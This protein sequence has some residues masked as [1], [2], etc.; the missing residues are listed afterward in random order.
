[1]ARQKVV[2]GKKPAQLQREIDSVLARS[3]HAI[4]REV[5]A[6]DWDVAMDAIIEGDPKRAATIVKKIIEEHGT[7]VSETPEFRRALRAAPDR[8]RKEFRKLTEDE[9]EFTRYQLIN[10]DVWGNERDGFEINQAFTTRHYVDIPKGAGSDEIVSILKDEGLIEATA[11][12][13]SIEINGEEGY[14][15]SFTDRPTGRPEFGLRAE[16]D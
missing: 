1:M 16:R 8:V 15:L 6:D 13:D 5:G 11:R 3:K 14:D 10:Y 7:T 2:A 12:K 4:K 9:T